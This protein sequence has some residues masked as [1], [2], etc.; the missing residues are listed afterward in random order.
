MNCFANNEI[1]CN[2]HFTQRSNLMK[3]PLRSVCHLYFYGPLPPLH[4]YGPLPPNDP[5]PLLQ[6]SVLWPSVLS[7]VLCLLDGPLPSSTALY[8]P[9]PVSTPYLQPSALSMALCLLSSMALCL[10]HGPLSSLWLSV[11]PS[12]PLYDPLSLLWP[13]V[14]S[15]SLCPFYGTL[16]P[17]L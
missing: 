7:T 13:S 8:L 1:F 5:L 15:S 16:S 4:L 2:T 10:L 6:P 12:V 14:P 3:F 11:R 17:L 9:P